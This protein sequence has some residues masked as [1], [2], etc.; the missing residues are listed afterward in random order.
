MVLDQ[1]FLGGKT[2]FL[3]PTSY[4]HSSEKVKMYYFYYI[5]ILL[6]IT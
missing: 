4:F 5:I 1:P 6:F 2:F 3:D